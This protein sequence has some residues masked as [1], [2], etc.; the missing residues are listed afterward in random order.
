MPELY[1]IPLERQVFDAMVSRLRL[2][3][4][5][6]PAKMVGVTSFTSKGLPSLAGYKISGCADIDLSAHIGGTPEAFLSNAA[7]LYPLALRLGASL[8]LAPSGKELSSADDCDTDLE[9]GWSPEGCFV[10]VITGVQFSGCRDYAAK[11]D[12]LNVM[13]RCAGLLDQVRVVAT[14]GGMRVESSVFKRLGGFGPS[15]CLA[16]Q[17]GGNRFFWHAASS[18]DGTQFRDLRIF[19]P[20]L[21]E[22]HSA[23][24]KTLFDGF[25]VETFVDQKL[26]I[27]STSDGYESLR[28]AV[29]SILP[30]ETWK[31]Q[32]FAVQQY[33]MENISDAFDNLTGFNLTLCTFKCPKV[34]SMD[35]LAV[36]G[37]GGTRLQFVFEK[38]DTKVYQAA[39]AFAADLAGGR[40]VID[41]TE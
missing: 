3:S 16:N 22:A 30:S 13:L 5:K 29:S 12:Q 32:L 10:H 25:G 35:V 26:T 11:A 14:E 31:I 19:F 2:V 27:V 21:A 1:T 28:S 40:D 6:S 24:L 36:H 18:V 38:N 7:K 39:K 17:E 37:D 8:R 4:G 33:G 9:L 23:A 20:S 41:T 15:P 34:G